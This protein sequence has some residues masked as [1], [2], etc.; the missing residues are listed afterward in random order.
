MTVSFIEN[1]IEQ[2]SLNAEAGLGTTSQATIYVGQILSSMF[3][4]SLVMNNLGLKWTMVVCQLSYSTYI[5]AQFYATF[6][7]LIPS[8]ALVGVAAAPL[9]SPVL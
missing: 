8:A 5:A 7:T 4:P 1:D 9:V 3:I 6:Y 2:S